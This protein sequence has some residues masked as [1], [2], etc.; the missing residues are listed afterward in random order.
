MRQAVGF[1]KVFQDEPYPTHENHFPPLLYT[2]T[3]GHPKFE[4]SCELLTILIESRYTVNVA[5][6]ALIDNPYSAI[7][8]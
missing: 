8:S 6:S 5:N 4:I 2:G 3:I 7:S 1:L